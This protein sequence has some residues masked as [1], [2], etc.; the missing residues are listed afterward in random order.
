MAK[1]SCH[2]NQLSHDLCSGSGDLVS[3]LPPVQR[4]SISLVQEWLL[5]LFEDEMISLACEN[6]YMTHPFIL[7]ISNHVNHGCINFHQSCSLKEL[8]LKFVYGSNRCFDRFRTV[9]KTVEITIMHI[10]NFVRNLSP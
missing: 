5:W 6:G 9:S 10:Y 7:A 8:Q 1:Y 4:K 2:G 3:D